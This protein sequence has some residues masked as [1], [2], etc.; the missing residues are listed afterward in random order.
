MCASGREYYTTPASPPPKKQKTKKNCRPTIEL[1]YECYYRFL[2]QFSQELVSNSS[3]SSRGR[4]T[5]SGRKRYKLLSIQKE[6]AMAHD[7]LKKRR[8]QG[9]EKKKV[10]QDSC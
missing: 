5:P 10:S 4:K 3:P 6:M 9:N 2:I 7:T 8:L 1:L